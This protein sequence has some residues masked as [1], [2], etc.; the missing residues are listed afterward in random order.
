LKKIDSY[1]NASTAET[2][3]VYMSENYH[4]FFMEKKGEGDDKITSLNDLKLGTANWLP[5]L[6]YLIIVR[7][8]IHGWFTLM[9]KMI[10]QN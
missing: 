8:E 6:Q 4:S 10:S 2:K 5:M 1:L 7:R 9:N 3:A